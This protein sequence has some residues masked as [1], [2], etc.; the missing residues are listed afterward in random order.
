L[1]LDT[2]HPADPAGAET[3][4]I[5]QAAPR[6]NRWQYSRVAPYLGRR[7]CEVGSGIGNM[8]TL[9]LDGAP[10]LL[11][12]T[13]TDHYYR[14]AL[15]QRFSARQ[16]VLVE[17]LTLP[18]YMAGSRFQEFRLDTVVALNVIEHIA[19]DLEALRC[20]RDMLQP[21]GRAV[22]LVPALEG[23]F[24]SLDSALG[25]QRRYTRRS[26]S[27][28]MRQAGFRVERVF[29]FNLLGT[30]GWWLSARIRKVQRIPLPQL[31]YFDSLVPVLRIEDWFRLPFGQSVIAVGAVD[32]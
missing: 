26:I 30:I 18:D 21:Q 9:L 24:G 17:E 25:H 5:M 15:Q 29:Y 16:H 22:I 12:L 6:Y 2:I 4:E 28:L 23:L 3:L 10:E 31:R 20:I 1:S 14:E 32:G 27:D 8:S 19:G 7:I 11:V 13:D